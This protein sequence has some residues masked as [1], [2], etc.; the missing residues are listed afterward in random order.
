MEDQ[1]N[2]NKEMIIPSAEH[3]VGSTTFKRITSGSD[4]WGIGYDDDLYVTINADGTP[5][6]T[7]PVFDEEGTTIVSGW[8]SGGTVTDGL[9]NGFGADTF[10][11]LWAEIKAIGVILPQEVLDH[12]ESLGYT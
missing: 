1:Y 6:M 4:Y 5:L 8:L 2:L 3:T 11:N 9:S 12:L 10:D 7:I